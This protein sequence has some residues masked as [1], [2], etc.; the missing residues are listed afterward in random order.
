MNP[1]ASRNKHPLQ[2]ISHE[3]PTNEINFSRT[4]HFVENNSTNNS[5]QISIHISLKIDN[6]RSQNSYSSKLNRGFCET[7]KCGQKFYAFPTI[8][9]KSGV[10]NTIVGI[11]FVEYS[12]GKEYPDNFTQ[13]QQ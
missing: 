2:F 9:G 13:V 5:N 10:Q 3:R 4:R 6:D 8:S 11:K 7:G 12:V 1:S